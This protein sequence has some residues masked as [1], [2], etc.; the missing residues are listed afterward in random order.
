MD[1]HWWFV[2]NRLTYENWELLQGQRPDPA[3]PIDKLV[4]VVTP[5]AG[6]GFLEGSLADDMSW[7]LGI[8]PGSMYIHPTA[9]CLRSFNLIYNTWYR[10]Q[11]LIDS[12]P[13][14]TGDGPDAMTNYVRPRRG[15]R[16]DQFTSALPF[17]QKGTAPTLSL[18]TSA[19]VTVT[20]PGSA[21]PAV[22]FDLPGQGFQGLQL[23]GGAFNPGIVLIQN[24]ALDPTAPAITPYVL[25]GSLTLTGTADLTGATAITVNALR[26]VVAIQHLLE[27]YAR[28]GTRYTET[29]H[30]LFGV[31]SPDARLQRPE[32]LGGTTIPIN[33]HTVVNQTAT[34]AGPALGERKSFGHGQFSGMAP[35]LHSFTEHGVILLIGSVRQEYRYWQGLAKRFTRRTLYDF[36]VPPLANL[37]EE[38]VAVSELLMDGS[39]HDQDTFGYQERWYAYRNQQSKVTHKMRPSATGTLAS[40]HLAQEFTNTPDPLELNQDF[41]EENPPMA[42]VVAVP[43]EPIFNADLWFTVHATRP[44]PLF[45]VPGLQTL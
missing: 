7:P 9:L 11:N 8:A 13:V 4:P 45:S 43:S 35:A 16:K 10:D 32:Y 26:Q 3:T 19:P 6:T 44:L 20:G 22:G 24:P 30:S 31:T 33:I 39:A 15:K 34:A 41:I 28:G 42:R 25:A 2:P 18:G 1:L 14:P 36:Y 5:P 38:P 17:A 23:Q 27:L 40:F 21:S 12:L 37:G 29:I